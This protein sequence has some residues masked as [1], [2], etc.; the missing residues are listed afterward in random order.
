[1]EETRC[2]SPSE[3]ISALT[4]NS[5]NVN[6]V[7]VWDIIQTE[8]LQGNVGHY[9]TLEGKEVEYFVRAP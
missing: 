3:V 9:E 4:E 8:S 1:M 6:D 7:S 2:I 5:H